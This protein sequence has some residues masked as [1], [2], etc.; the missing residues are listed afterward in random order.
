[1]Y[2]RLSHATFSLRKSTH[3]FV[4]CF[5]TSDCCCFC[6]SSSNI[7]VIY[8]LQLLLTTISPNYCHTFLWNPLLKCIE[9][10]SFSCAL[11]VFRHEVSQIYSLH[12][13]S[14]GVE[15][16]R[17]PNRFD[18][19]RP[20]KS[21]ERSEEGE[22]LGVPADEAKVFRGTFLRVL[23]FNDNGYKIWFSL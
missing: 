6:I 8:G 23:Q 19:H 11:V 18:L 2:V 15:Y 10:L 14:G 5:I 12:G 16:L 9:S 22:G 21:H 4:L 7:F 1:M 13:F 17:W 3:R 20:C